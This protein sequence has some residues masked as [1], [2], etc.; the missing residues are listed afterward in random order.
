MVFRVEEPSRYGVVVSDDTGK[1]QS[2]V[3]KPKQFISNCINAG[4]YVFNTSMIDRIEPRPTSIEREIFPKMSADGMLYS[5]VLDG[6]WMD[7]GQPKDFI[8]GTSLYLKA[9]R[10]KDPS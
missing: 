2:F 10:A 4:M 6:F 5:F 9:L 8:I 1:I 3:E 7:V